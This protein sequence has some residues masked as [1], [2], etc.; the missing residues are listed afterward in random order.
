MIS[1]LL[2]GVVMYW[3][4]RIVWRD[5]DGLPFHWSMDHRFLLR[6]EMDAAFF[7]LYGTARDDAVYILRSLPNTVHNIAEAHGL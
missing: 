3:R 7:H 4:F 5:Y 6:C 2:K 1:N